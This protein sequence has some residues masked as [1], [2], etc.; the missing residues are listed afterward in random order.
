M[1]RQKDILF[2]ESWHHNP[3]IETAFELAKRHLDA[4]DK[5][6]FYF[7]GHDLPY[8]DDG[9]D[10]FKSKRNPAKL[11]ERILARLIKHP[12]LEFTPSVL[13]AP[14]NLEGN[15]VF[16]N[17]SELKNYRYK[18]CNIGLAAYSSLMYQLRLSSPDVSKEEQTLYNMLY[19]GAQAFDLA[20]SL[21]EKHNPDL[22]YIFNGRFVNNRSF[23]EAALSKNI[24]IL[25]HERGCNKDYFRIE[26]YMPH[27]K[28]KFQDDMLSTWSTARESDKEYIWKSRKYFIDKRKGKDDKWYSFTATQ[29]KGCLPLLDKEK[30]IITY[31]TSSD[32]ESKAVGDI[33]KWNR[34]PNQLQA[35]NDLINICTSIKNI[36]LVIR[37]HPNIAKK[38][39]YDQ[40][41][42]N[43]LSERE[44]IIVIL[45]E[46]KVDTYALIDASNVVIT[47]GSTTGIEAVYWNTPSVC[48]GP[49]RYSKLGAVYEPNNNKELKELIIN[50]KLLKS[51]PELSLPYG[52]FL[53]TFGHKFIYYKARSL[54]SGTF[55]GVDAHAQEPTHLH[56]KFKRS[57][58]KCFSVKAYRRYIQ[59]LATLRGDT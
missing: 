3:H 17:E 13:L 4:G 18:G 42:Y 15:I 33:V 54:E 49:S 51:K 35:L 38:H 25:I 45:P 21:I 56:H 1:Q 37:V 7:A 57:L 8:R 12:N 11:P 44:D 20:V 43:K 9:I 28:N 39:P 26:D 48:L 2:I 14:V 59:T 6:Y 46:S 47:T 10:Q 55:L 19:S 16:A 23:M 30:T 24:P 50:A 34:W 27:D 58:A 29:E 41:F 36:T 53:S 31:F 52:Y 40:Q 32:D 5:V 22:M